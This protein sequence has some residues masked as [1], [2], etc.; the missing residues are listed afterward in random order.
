MENLNDI[1]LS[2]DTDDS[3]PQAPV[4]T[5]PDDFGTNSSN[6]G[7]SAELSLEPIAPKPTVVFTQVESGAALVPDTSGLSDA[8]RKLIADFANKIDLNNSTQIMHYG[9]QAQKK[10]S[11]FS[12]AALANIKT[13]DVDEIGD[14]VGGLVVQLKNF[15]IDGTNEKKPGLFRRAKNKFALTKAKYDSVEKNV[16]KISD[17]LE[18]HKITLMK[19]VHLLDQ[20]YDKNLEYYK[21]LTMYIIAG[22]QKLQE[23]IET[24]LPQLQQKAIESGLQ[25]DA[26]SANYL[27][28][29]CNRFDK[30][31]HDLELTRIVSI[32]MGPQIR[33]VQSTNNI[34]V[35]KIHSSIVNTI[36]LWKNQMVLALGMAHS[37]A[38][39]E[40]QRAVT[41]MTNELL[42]KNADML[43]ENTIEAAKESERSIVDIDT[44]RHTNQSLIATLD[45]VLAIQ[46]SGREKRREA[47]AEL[48]KIEDELKTKLLDIRDVTRIIASPQNEQIASP[49]S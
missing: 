5:V 31:I 28:D 35:E 9:T 40:S 20:M 39:I 13:K 36:P 15:D 32:Q 44:L 11:S 26:Q 8:E 49:E 17:N 18:Q 48:H 10:V 23:V 41:D 21:E 30:K 34:M 19:D 42:R 6:A 47:Q 38:A 22:R 24:Q 29:M 3:E 7:E 43:K 25:E 2:L 12:E 27:A 1:K 16:N 14:M 46:Q 37:K 33:L 4:F 45:E